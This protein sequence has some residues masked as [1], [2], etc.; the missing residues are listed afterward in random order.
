MISE[1]VFYNKDLSNAIRDIV[2][3]SPCTYD[4]AVK[5]MDKSKNY[6]RDIHVIK[7]LLNVGISF[8]IVLSII[9]N[10]NTE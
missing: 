2:I 4:N 7:N 1:Y 8:E 9:I 6:A 10:L 5:L 3:N